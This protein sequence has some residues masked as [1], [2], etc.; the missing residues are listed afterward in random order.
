MHNFKLKNK[1]TS[2]VII[3]VSPTRWNLVEVGTELSVASKREH[4]CPSMQRLHRVFPACRRSNANRTRRAPIAI[5]PE[6]IT[7]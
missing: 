5:L 2:T 7:E 6:I 1:N 4:L 3:F